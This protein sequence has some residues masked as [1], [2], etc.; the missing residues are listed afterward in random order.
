MLVPFAPL[1]KTEW[2]P[3]QEKKERLPADSL[4]EKEEGSEDEAAYYDS[5]SDASSSS[6]ESIE[7]E[8]EMELADYIDS[9]IPKTPPEGGVRPKAAWEQDDIFTPKAKKK[10]SGWGLQYIYN[11]FQAWREKERK[12]RMQGIYK[13]YEQKVKAYDAHLRREIVHEIKAD[14]EAILREM[15]EVEKRIKANSFVKQK[16]VLA[17]EE[18]DKDFA[19]R[20]EETAKI[21]FYCLNLQRWAVERFGEADALAEAER[22]KELQEREGKRLERERVARLAQV[23]EDNKILGVDVG[24]TQD[25]L[26]IMRG[27]GQVAGVNP[28]T[29]AGAA[30]KKKAKNKVSGK[31]KSSKMSKDQEAKMEADS[32]VL[33]VGLQEHLDFSSRKRLLVPYVTPF[34]TDLSAAKTSRVVVLKAKNIGER[35]A[36]C[37][38]AE[39][40]R[41][42]C[43]ALQLLDLSRCEVKTRGFGRLIHGV[44]MANLVDLRTLVLRGNHIEARG[45]EHLKEVFASGVFAS[46]AV[47]DLRENELGD[48]GADVVMRMIIG[49]SFRALSELYLQSNFISDMGFRKVV[50]AMQAMQAQTF[51]LVRRVGLELNNV[52]F[53]V[54]RELSPI[55]LYI[56]V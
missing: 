42:A 17:H 26:R 39:F 24:I 19:K 44:R 36:L 40:L 52:S 23:E 30:K 45:M 50:K 53:Q 21:E 14:E 34:D 43:P 12:R 9:L 11:K 13:V 3:R 47:L 27:T 10:S 8:E 5:S 32:G 51:P 31:K 37:L 20:D 33:R 15:H 22:A 38:G 35:G 55:P 4:E 6:E 41:G 49:G 2:H 7:P 48:D 46:L 29:S 25:V 18:F 1:P 28:R 54:K 16:A 56:S